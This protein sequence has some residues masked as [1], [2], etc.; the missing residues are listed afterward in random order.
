MKHNYSVAI[1]VALGMFSLMGCVTDQSRDG[2]NAQTIVGHQVVE[3]L[4]K[5]RSVVEFSTTKRVFGGKLWAVVPN[6]VI[7]GELE[8]VSFHWHG[9]D[10]NRRYEDDPAS[11]FHRLAS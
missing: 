8:T 2:S 5:G 3:E 6:E 1:I 9:D 11:R 4:H 10:D 7:R